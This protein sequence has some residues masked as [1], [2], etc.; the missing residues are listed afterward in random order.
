MD[1]S[2]V[3][4]P[5]CKWLPFMM[6]M[7]K[8][9]I[10][11]PGGHEG[12]HESVRLCFIH[13]VR[14]QCENGV[15]WGERRKRGGG[16]YHL[17]IHVLSCKLPHFFSLLHASSVLLVFHYRSVELEWKAAA[18]LG[19]NIH[20]FLEWSHSRQQSLALYPS[21]CPITSLPPLSHSLMITLFTPVMHTPSNPTQSSQLTFI[22]T[23][24]L[25]AAF[26]R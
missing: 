25:K 7:Q 21:P 4:V 8:S 24:C 23:D 14:L 2:S 1:M 18:V 12:L 17:S 10:D 26:Y 15:M 13:S 9:H 3:T 20:G 19:F 16:A 22:A 11:K 5:S 6:L